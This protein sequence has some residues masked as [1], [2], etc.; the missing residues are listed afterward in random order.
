MGMKGGGVGAA[1]GSSG[2]DEAW[3]RA[4]GDGD[5]DGKQAAAVRAPSWRERENNRQRERCRRVIARRIF[6]GL[7]L[8]GNYALPRHCDNNNVLMALCEEA[9]WTVEADGTT[10]R[11][12]PKPDRAG[13]QHMADIGGS[14]PA[15]VKNPGGASYSLTRASSPSGIMLGGGGSG[16]SSD[17][18]PAW[19]KNQSKQ[20][21][22]NSY[23]N[24]FASSSNSKAPATPQDGSAPSSP[25]RLRKMSRYSS[26]PPSSAR[27]SASNSNVLPPPPW[28]TGAGASRFSFQTSTPPLM[29]TVNGRTP[30]PDPV[31]LLAGFQISNAAA[32]KQ[33]A[34]YSSSFVASGAS[35]LGAGSSASGSGWKPWMLPPLPG[36]SRSGAS[37]AIRG[38]GGALMSGRGGALMSGRGGALLSPL[39]FSFRR[40]GGEQAGA[41]EEDVMTEK[42]ADEEDGLELTLGNAA[43]RKDRA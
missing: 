38:R 41:R 26:P 39:G 15:P 22:D 2:G 25:L 33:A 6:A 23:P 20:L 8:Y 17:P 12:G 43:T 30:G 5:G 28:A 16:G 35:S 27:A 14:A 7:R 18:I 32:N 11:K 34:A 42:N 21:S 36:R 1:G 4:A 40:S 31:S 29:S 9:G 24:F 37:A 10:Y 19:L 13:D 3:A